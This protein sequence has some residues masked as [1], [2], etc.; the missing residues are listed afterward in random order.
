MVY[1]F[2][3]LLTPLIHPLRRSYI[4]KSTP[5]ITMAIYAHIHENWDEREPEMSNT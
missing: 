1:T 2:Y 5:H 3:V 4:T